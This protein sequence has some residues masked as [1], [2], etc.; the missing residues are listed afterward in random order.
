[1]AK[2][3]TK[4]KRVTRRKVYKRRTVKR[5]GGKREQ[6]AAAQAKA[7]LLAE[8]L[9][10][11]RAGAV[12]AA[13]A[14]AVAA[15]RAAEAA[16]TPTPR[17]AEAAKAELVCWVNLKNLAEAGAEAAGAAGTEL[18][19]IRNLFNAN[20][21][22]VQVA[23]AKINE[24]EA[25]IAYNNAKQSSS[26]QVELK[27]LH[28]S[29]RNTSDVYYK[30]KMAKKYIDDVNAA[31]ANASASASASGDDIYVRASDILEVNMEAERVANEAERAAEAR[32][33]ALEAEARA[34]EA[35]ARAVKAAA[36]VEEE[37][38]RMAEL[39][40]KGDLK[41]IENAMAH[42][43]VDADEEFARRL[44][45]EDAQVDADEVLARQLQD[46]ERGEEDA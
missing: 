25:R 13:A 15:A 9:A 42:A 6:L 39:E 14:V 38:L 46:E 31:L 1:M 30:M 19:L 7:D 12:E 10:G 3:A 11:A 45:K 41:R 33:A 24:A 2:R 8:M 44:Q 5:G 35:E 26:R 18:E 28:I 29:L 32:A 27:A 36:A 16:G 4:R 43:Q 22:L 21:F 40:L 37:K 20:M 34:V 17:T 23:E